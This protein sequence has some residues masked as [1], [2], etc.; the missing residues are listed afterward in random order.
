MK[1]RIFDWELWLFYYKYYP[2]IGAHGNGFYKQPKAIKLITFK[3]KVR[4]N[5]F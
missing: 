4:I 3:K 1:L 5:P 2:T